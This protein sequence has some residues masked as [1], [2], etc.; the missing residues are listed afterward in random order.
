M[1]GLCR[2]RSLIYVFS[3]APITITV[4]E[5]LLAFFK[6][7]AV[8]PQ[9]GHFAYGGFKVG[10]GIFLAEAQGIEIID[11]FALNGLC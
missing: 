2:G 6:Y 9:A 1:F 3:L 5:C 10:Y 4:P 7:Y 11:V 8:K